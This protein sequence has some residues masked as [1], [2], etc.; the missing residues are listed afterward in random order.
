MDLFVV[1]FINDISSLN[2]FCDHKVCENELV[3]N[4]KILQIKKQHN[5]EASFTNTLIAFF[6]IQ[7][8]EA[9]PA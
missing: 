5:L 3:K 9:H 8:S 6:I 1:T 2:E 4:I 7:T